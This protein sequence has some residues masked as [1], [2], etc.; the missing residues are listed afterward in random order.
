MMLWAGRG[1]TGDGQ[2][3]TQGVQC[4]QSAERRSG[5]IHPVI[6]RRM[7]D[8]RQSLVFAESPAVTFATNTFV[9]VPVIL[10][11]GDT[12]LIEVVGALDAG[13]TT[14]FV[15][16]DDSGTKMA[17]V[18]G[19]QIY[20]T[21]EGERDSIE[22]RHPQGKTICERGSQTLFELERI[23]PA[24]FKAA[25]E[26]YS[27]DGRFVVAQ[28]DVMPAL[29]ESGQPLSIGGLLLQGNYFNGVAVGVHI[30]SDGSIAIG[31]NG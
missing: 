2:S 15:I 31:S 7:T 12:P 3:A 14:Q 11:Y 1:T 23:G 13:F 20:L 6:L 24:A 26:L 8:D 25:A 30:R 10:K 21:S 29:F 19:T 16:Y 27:P 9:N 17:V 22:L 4:P 28:H 18:K 5:T